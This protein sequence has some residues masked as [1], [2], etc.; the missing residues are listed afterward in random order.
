MILIGQTTWS[1]GR[2]NQW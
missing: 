2:R 1:V